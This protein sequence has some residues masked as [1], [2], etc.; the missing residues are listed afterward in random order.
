[1]IYVGMMWLTDKP[2]PNNGNKG[3]KFWSQE[4]ENYYRN[5]IKESGFNEIMNDPE[6]YTY[7]NAKFSEGTLGTNP[8]KF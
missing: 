4:T 6:C 3:Y 7:F 5:K 8:C 1:M 2:D